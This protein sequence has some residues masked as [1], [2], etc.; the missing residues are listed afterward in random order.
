MASTLSVTPS[1][2]KIREAE[3]CLG[4]FAEDPSANDAAAKASAL[5]TATT[6]LVALLEA[7]SGDSPTRALETLQVV[8]TN[9]AI[10]RQCDDALLRQ[11][12]LALQAC[13]DRF[14]KKKPIPDVLFICMSG[15]LTI[16]R[17]RVLFD[18]ARLA[19]FMSKIAASANALFMAS[20]SA[21]MMLHCLACAACD[22]STASHFEP[23]ILPLVR[24]L[25]SEQRSEGP[26]LALA[27][28]QALTSLFDT[29]PGVREG[30]LT[31]QQ[32]LPALF[33]LP[34]ERPASLSFKSA[35]HAQ[36]NKAVVS[37][38]LALA[39]FICRVET[40]GLDP[41]AER[42][43]AAGVSEC[44]TR[45]SLEREEHSG[46]CLDA[47][48]TAVRYVAIS[49]DCQRRLGEAF[50]LDQLVSVF[51]SPVLARSDKLASEACTA[52]WLLTRLAANRERVASAHLLQ[53]VA[54]QVTTRSPDV[55]AAAL[56]ALSNAANN[57]SCRSQL[58]QSAPLI[59]G[60]LF[61]RFGQVES[62]LPIIV[63][64]TARLVQVMLEPSS[65]DTCGAFEAQARAIS[66]MV[67]L[68]CLFRDSE[69]A[70]PAGGPL[71]GLRLCQALSPLVHGV[72]HVARDMIAPMLVIIDF[73]D[74]S[75]NT[76]VVREATWRVLRD[77]LK[78]WGSLLQV[79]PQELP[80][81]VAHRME[82]LESKWGATE[83]TQECIVLAGR[84][85]VY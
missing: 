59:C 39:Q 62:Y 36:V 4:A 60:S 42:L 55:A 38:Q 9:K 40:S 16:P 25:V 19:E 22:V 81:W 84:A 10:L 76:P 26:R 32:L 28:V 11:L 64:R 57:A 17:Y 72:L 12:V 61:E 56:V 6:A 5:V 69:T 54:R 78:R 83:L 15:L 58:L 65:R 20:H 18:L 70:P 23:L 46:V 50:V 73:P 85:A 34:I 27:Q 29:C 75:G 31:H 30:V 33:R 14:R 51:D 24:S 48:T 13:C 45:M 66:P 2:E 47:F 41:N 3:I 35:E 49:P 44:L 74:A 52:I 79:R 63:Q 43:C 71:M 21:T 80:D 8:C 82:A 77:V 67:A 53:R 68:L 1:E 37:L 7:T